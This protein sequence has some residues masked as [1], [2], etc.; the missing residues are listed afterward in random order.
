MSQVKQKNKYDDFTP[1]EAAF[2]RSIAGNFDA[3]ADAKDRITVLCQILGLHFQ[4]NVERVVM[5]FLYD[6]GTE[7]TAEVTRK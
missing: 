3:E 7:G 6:D 1:F 4:H 5:T 2:V